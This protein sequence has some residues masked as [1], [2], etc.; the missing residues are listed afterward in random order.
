[1]IGGYGGNSSGV[2]D[3]AAAVALASADYAKAHGLTPRA[4]VVATSNLGDDPTLMLNAPVPA[5]RKVLRKAGLTLDDIEAKSL[6]MPE[7]VAALKTGAVDASLLVPPLDALAVQD[8]GED[9]RIARA[10]TVSPAAVACRWPWPRSGR[11]RAS[12]IGTRPWP[13]V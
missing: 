4:R 8:G 13:H 5:A 2:V 10:V 3:G 11:C 1:M 7:T 6:G 12:N 9:S